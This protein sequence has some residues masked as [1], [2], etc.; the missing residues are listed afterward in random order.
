MATLASTHVNP[1]H[2]FQL[3]TLREEYLTRL[4]KARSDI[5][6]RVAHLRSQKQS[7]AASLDKLNSEKTNLRDRAAVLSER[8]EDLQDNGQRL[9]TRIEIVLQKLQR[10]VCTLQC[11]W[12]TVLVTLFPIPKCVTFSDIVSKINPD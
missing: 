3:Q 9:R 7:Q 11:T 4:E 2:C 8:Y 6:R 5:E 10:Q 12:Q 1:S